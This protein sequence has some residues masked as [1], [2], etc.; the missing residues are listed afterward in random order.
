MTTLHYRLSELADE[1]QG[2]GAPGDLWSRG[3]RLHRRQ[4]LGSGI[5][6]ATVVVLLAGILGLSWMRS[7]VD[8]QPAS[9]VGRLGLPDRFY[10]PPMR[11]PST[12][13][14]GPIGPL[15]AIMEG[16][17]K[18]VGISAT[19]QYGLLE[20]PHQADLTDYSAPGPPVLSA[21]GT[22][23]AYW[24]TGG[25]TD[26]AVDKHPVVGVSVYDTVTGDVVEYRVETVH[27]LNPED[28]VWAG[29][30]VWFQVWQYDAPTGDGSS[31]SR[32]QETVMWNPTDDSSRIRTPHP[33]GLN[34]L[35]GVST[36]DGAVVELGGQGTLRLFRP[37]RTEVRARVV[38]P[39]L[40]EGPMY[41]DDAG[42]RVVA[43]R[44]TDGAAATTDADLPVLI[45]NL[46]DPGVADPEPTTLREVPGTADAGI[47][48]LLGWRDDQHVIGYRYGEDVE[49]GFVTV[50]VSTGEIEVIS[51]LVDSNLPHL[52][53][54]AL[55]GPVFEAPLPPNPLDPRFT[56]AGVVLVLLAGAGALVWWRRRV[57]R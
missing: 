47:Q 15:S 10:F 14:T 2:D 54:G 44:D 19:G 24:S 49:P 39:P 22:R 26:D 42:M 34:G 48:I 17:E 41:L 35:Y 13:D 28:I 20:L 8:V 12:E 16:L 56:Y 31:G 29:D 18:P 53:E 46:P 11:V 6:V 45:G 30:D 23:L 52:A 57:Q 50:D 7:D 25:S 5:V 33:E 51:V 37:D 38:D 40:V 1:A 32:L 27:G 4:Q 36:W 21:D 55:S 43:L 3:L 9:E